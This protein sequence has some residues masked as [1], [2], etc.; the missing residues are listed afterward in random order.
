M[1]YLFIYIYIRNPFPTSPVE[2]KRGQGVYDKH[3]CKLGRG[4]FMQL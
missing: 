3:L 4:Y 1:T 2:N